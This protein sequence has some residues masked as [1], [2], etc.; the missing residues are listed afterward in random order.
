LKIQKNQTTACFAERRKSSFVQTSSARLG[1]IDPAA[2]PKF[3]VK[4]T[5]G[6]ETFGI[7]YDNSPLKSSTIPLHENLKDCPRA[8]KNSQRPPR[9]ATAPRN[10]GKVWNGVHHARRTT[11]SR[12]VSINSRRQKHK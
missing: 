6:P 5:G 4:K 1:R 10:Q 2:N 9:E 11:M 7:E 12:H 3:D 8:E